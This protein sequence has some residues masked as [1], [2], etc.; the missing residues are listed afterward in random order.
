MNVKKPGTAGAIEIQRYVR[1]AVASSHHADSYDR[2]APAELA[3]W[4]EKA[5]NLPAV[6]QDLV[7]RVKAE[8]AAGVYETPEKL[9]IAAERLIE[10]ISDTA[11]G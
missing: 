5:H 4:I 1:K 10:E 6:R 2:P 9:Q 7:D 8:I 3:H 11:S